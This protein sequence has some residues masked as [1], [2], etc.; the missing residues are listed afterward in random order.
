[1]AFGRSRN[2]RRQDTAQQREAVK[3]A[4]RTRGPAVLK[5]ILLAGLTCGLVWGG[6]ELRRWAL[7]SP[8][9]LLKETTF[10]GL[11]R[12]T[13][14]ELLKLSGLTVGQNLWALDV[15]SLERAMSA[16]PWA[17]TVVVTR[18]FPSSVSVEVTEHVP[19]A[20]AVLGDLYLLDEEGEPFKR[21]QPGDK[22]DLPL[23]T[24]VD[25]E[26]YLGDE[27]GMRERYR[28]ALAVV[29]AYEATGPGKRERLSEVRV[30]PEGTVLV[31]ADGMEVRLGEGETDAKLRKLARVR[32]ELRARGLSA[33]I[34]HLDNRARPGWVAVKLSS[35]VSE[36]NGASQ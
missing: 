27:A 4:V 25:R 3:G 6:L 1:M 8:T 19:A 20:L 10:S 30:S 15:E 12:A 33:E 31:L 14:G 26:S 35:P 36:R 34:I 13:P 16:H 17:R 21:L 23:V 22:L 29:E 24:G 32:E 2:R 5:A 7:T 11:Q 9:F 28:R 18:H